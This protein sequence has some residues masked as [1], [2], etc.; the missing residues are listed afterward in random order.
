[1]AK[2]PDFKALLRNIESTKTMLSSQKTITNG[3]LI[4]PGAKQSQNMFIHNKVAKT[5]E[6][7][8]SDKLYR[9]M[10][11]GKIDRDLT[12]DEIQKIATET[13]N[14]ILDR[15]FEGF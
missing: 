4:G 12:E 10:V 8:K 7:A 14:K 1:M 9:D 11:M 6:D 5:V 13:V 2:F 3:K 15:L